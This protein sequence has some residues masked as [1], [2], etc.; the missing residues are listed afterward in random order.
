MALSKKFIGNRIKR[1]NEIYGTDYT[2]TSASDSRG[3]VYAVRKP[4]SSLLSSFMKLKE[5]DYFIDGLFAAK[6]N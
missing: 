5:M 3:A 1:F 4:N 2:V 6:N